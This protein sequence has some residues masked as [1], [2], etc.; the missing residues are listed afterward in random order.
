MC[1]LFV[2]DGDDESFF[3]TRKKIDNEKKQYRS[4]TLKLVN[5]QK[6]KKRGGKINDRTDIGWMDWWHCSV[7][8]VA[9][10]PDEFTSLRKRVSNQKER[11]RDD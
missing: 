9:Y 1:A 6:K 3:R 5:F 10:D 7:Y 11:E 8:P 4:Y 2:Y